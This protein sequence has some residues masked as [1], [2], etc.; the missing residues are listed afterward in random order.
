M[1][2]CLLRAQGMKCN[3]FCG[4]A[5]KHAREPRQ[6]KTKKTRQPGDANF[7]IA[8]DFSLRNIYY[9]GFGDPS[10]RAVDEHYARCA[11]VCARVR[12]A[13]AAAVIANS[14]PSRAH[15]TTSIILKHPSLPKQQ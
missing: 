8:V 6:N 1:C 2:V 10:P 7:D 15:T 11:C 3:A 4:A 12:A 5:R 13:A 14:A 9:H